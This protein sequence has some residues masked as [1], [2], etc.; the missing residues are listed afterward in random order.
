MGCCFSSDTAAAAAS[1]ALHTA[2]NYLDP[3]APSSS[4]PP[5][6]GQQVIPNVHVFKMPD[7]DTFTARYPSG[8]TVRV[9]ILGIDCPETRQNYG[10]EA[11]DLGRRLIHNQNVT[12]HV[13]DTD[14]YGR[15]VADV[16]MP[17][18]QSFGE[19]MLAAGAAWHYKAY[20]KRPH[21]A[22]LEN[23]ARQARRGLWQFAR[24]QPPWDY[25]KRLRENGK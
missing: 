15:I 4:T 9:R 20:D 8:E 12:L 22:S 1:N 16:I 25:R 3:S 6:P 17:N 19:A 5:A 7:G 11:G 14:R 2:A 24:P 23:E 21:L 13:A 18:G 10:R